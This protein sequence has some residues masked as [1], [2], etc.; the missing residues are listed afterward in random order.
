MGRVVGGKVLHDAWRGVS[1]LHAPLVTGY[2][3]G[4]AMPK[5]IERSM[6]CMRAIS[7]V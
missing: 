4:G 2:G 3:D 7:V 1:A 5:V 6:R